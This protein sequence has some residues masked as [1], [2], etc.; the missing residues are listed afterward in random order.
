MKKKILIIKFVIASQNM[1]IRIEV[2]NL[3]DV[4]EQ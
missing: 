4:W 2:K 3:F 1:L